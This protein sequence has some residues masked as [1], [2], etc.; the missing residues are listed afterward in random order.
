MIRFLGVL[1]T[2]VL[3]MKSLDAAAYKEQIM[4]NLDKLSQVDS[5]RKY[6][7][8]DLSTLGSVSQTNRMTVVYLCM[9]VSLAKEL[10]SYGKNL[11]CHWDWPLN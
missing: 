7:Y 6:Y 3:L 10:S 5:Y 4:S 2:I 11:S 8:L 1:L 9:S